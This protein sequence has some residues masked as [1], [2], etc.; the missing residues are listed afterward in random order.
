MFKNKIAAKLAIY[1]AICLLVFSVIIGI[2]FMVLFY[3]HTTRLHKLEL[4]Q[5]AL[6]IARTLSGFMGN[7][8]GLQ[9]EHS[10]Y[11]AYLSSLD[12]IAMTD[13]WIVDDN[14]ELITRGQGHHERESLSYKDLPADANQVIEAVFS[15]KTAFSESFGTLLNQPTITV[16]TPIKSGDSIIGVVLLHSPV[17]GISAAI[18]QGLIM[19]ITS[20]L[21]ALVIAFLLSL[22]L[23]KNFTDPIISKE[24]SEALRLETLRRDFIANISH[25]LKTPVAVLRGSLE[26]LVDNVVTDPWQVDSYHHEMLSETL[27]LQRLVGDLLDLSRLQNVVF[28]M[29]LQDLSI[30]DVLDDAIRSITH[31]AQEKSVTI[32]LQ[33][34]S[35]PQ[36]V[37][38]DYGRLRQMLLIVLDNAVKFSPVKGIVTVTLTEKSLTIKDQGNGIPVEN[39]PYLFDRFYKSHSEQ[40]KTGTGLGLAI[41][42]QIAERHGFNLTANNSADAGASFQFTF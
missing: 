20:I 31:I 8:E 26:A 36:I 6:S 4:E 2:T 25:E 38:G 13:V 42:K 28:A 34:N 23:S 18:S 14:L 21:A 17:N 15:G 7:G 5:R 33:N 27:Y 40:N 10:G 30:G 11:N 12:N 41:A 39:L 1:F 37:H 3:N 24:A 19:L 9:D 29:D 32:T 16:G 35:L 22:W